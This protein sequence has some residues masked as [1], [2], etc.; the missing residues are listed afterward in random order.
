M[1]CVK[2]KVLIKKKKPVTDSQ[3]FTKLGDQIMSALQDLKDSIATLAADI[4]AEKAEVQMLLQALKD[5]VA[6]LQT[7]GGATAEELAAVTAS[8]AGV[9]AAV[10]DISEPSTP[11][12]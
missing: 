2:K 8:I 3:L 12:A 11:P 10:K 6:A 1:K 5:Q 7:A 4:A 9:D